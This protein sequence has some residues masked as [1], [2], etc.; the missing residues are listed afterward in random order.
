M[1]LKIPYLK[2]FL[3]IIYSISINYPYRI[4]DFLIHPHF[5]LTTLPNPRGYLYLFIYFIIK[6]LNM[7]NLFF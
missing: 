7:S 4:L 6:C 1:K 2:I 5:S 3:Y